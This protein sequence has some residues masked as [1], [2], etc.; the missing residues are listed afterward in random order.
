MNKKLFFKPTLLFKEY[1]ILD[2]IE[3]NQNV[4]QREI[5]SAVSN[6]VS[7]VNAYL[8]TIE[9]MGLLEKERKTSK[10]VVYHITKKGVERKK[11][12]YIGYL[13][14]AQVLYDRAKENIERFLIQIESK[15]FKKILLY[16]AGEVAEILLHSIVSSKTAIE[17]LAVIDDNPSRQT[18][19]LVGKKIISLEEVYKY[20]YE[21]IFISSYTNN[22]TIYKKLIKND[23]PKDKIVQ[24]F[25]VWKLI[26]HSSVRY[27]IIYFFIIVTSIFLI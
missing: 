23:F 8:G 13:N 26:I 20:E 18:S 27:N 3:K 6:T 21:G 4:T 5:A 14:N 12:L 15:G 11:L 19:F 16:G 17:V 2:M 9:S 24:Y 1:I 25:D 7:M 22:E 10:N